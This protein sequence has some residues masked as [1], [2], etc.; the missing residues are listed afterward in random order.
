VGWQVFATFYRDLIENI[1]LIF[2]TFSGYFITFYVFEGCNFL[3]GGGEGW[4]DGLGIGMVKARIV[5]QARFKT[6]VHFF[7]YDL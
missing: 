2:D 1:P 4:G 7:K 3:L 5:Y 6:S